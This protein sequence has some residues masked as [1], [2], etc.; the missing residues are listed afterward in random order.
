MLYICDVWQIPNLPM[1]PTYNCSPPIFISLSLFLFLSLYIYRYIS[2]SLHYRL[3][4]NIPSI[5]SLSQPRNRAKKM[6]S[7]K[8]KLGEG[9]SSGVVNRRP[10]L[11]RCNSIPDRPNPMYACNKSSSMVVLNKSKSF[12][13]MSSEAGSIA[14]ARREQVSIL[15]DQRKMRI[16]HYGRTPKSKPPNST[17]QHSS[18]LLPQRCTFITPNSDPIY[19]AY[20]DQE[21]GVPV[22]DDQ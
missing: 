13:Y 17:D 11:E 12:N 5:I 4:L 3:S 10:L 6:C 16:A 20:H 9:S 22:H 21:W 1:L 2:I 19:V 14:A 15:Q 8:S 7:F 18:T